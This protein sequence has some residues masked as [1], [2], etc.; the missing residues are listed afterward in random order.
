MAWQL[1]AAAL[2]SVAQAAGQYINRPREEEFKPQ[3]GYMK[4]YLSHLRG[5]QADRDVYHMAMRPALRAIGGQSRKMQRQIG[6]QTER[7]GVSGSGIE[8]QQRLTAGQMTMGAMQEASEKATA[9]QM[10]ESRRL[11]DTA[12]DVTAKIGAEEERASQAYK[13]AKSQWGRQ[14]VSTGLQAAGALAGQGISQGI[15]NKESLAFGTEHL[16]AEKVKSMTAAGVSPDDIKQIAQEQYKAE[17][18]WTGK[19]GEGTLDQ[20]LSQKYLD[21]EGAGDGADTDPSAGVT[22][23]EPVVEP[24]VVTD[25]AAE[26]ETRQS[27]QE[28]LRKG[29]EEELAAAKAEEEQYVVDS[30]TMV[31]KEDNKWYPGKKLLEHRKKRIEE[32]KW[33][34]GELL[35]EAGRERASDRRQTEEARLSGFSSPEEQRLA[36][37]Y[38][39]AE[40]Q[41]LAEEERKAAEES[42]QL[43]ESRRARISDPEYFLKEGKGL[44]KEKTLEVFRKSKGEAGKE[45]REK[46]MLA[47]R[48]KE[49]YEKGTEEQKRAFSELEKKEI[50]TIKGVDYYVDEKGEPIASIVPLT[51]AEKF[52]KMTPFEKYV[53]R[54]EKSGGVQYFKT[55]EEWLAGKDKHRKL[56]GKPS[57]EAQVVPEVSD[58]PESAEQVIEYQTST[59]THEQKIEQNQEL[60]KEMGSDYEKRKGETYAQ[61]KERRKQYYINWKKRTK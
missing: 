26:G 24:K 4:K 15:Q 2:P 57:E 29:H 31:E 53:Y 28:R 59:M 10:V 16:G 23:D 52:E 33:V 45:L 14:M 22:E 21:V 9:A 20:Y 50:K 8:A 13:T 49:I 36:E 12:A 38:A 46:E 18:Y 43:D 60:K 34:A 35:T 11:G 39:F 25:N 19:L 55:E 48:K 30:E 1:L 17:L 58:V 40:E 32:G 5:R 44:T 51:A 7:A 42:L 27:Y 61:W 3:T 41:R 47:K 54:T 56:H 6:Y 37:E